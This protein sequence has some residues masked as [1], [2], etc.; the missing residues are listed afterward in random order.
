MV[1]LASQP[2]VSVFNADLVAGI[3]QEI[4]DNRRAALCPCH[5]T[6][7]QLEFLNIAEG[8]GMLDGHTGVIRDWRRRILNEVVDGYWV[9][10]IKHTQECPSLMLG[11]SGTGHQLL[12]VAHSKSVPSILTLDEVRSAK[13]NLRSPANRL[14]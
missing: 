8:R 7:G 10:D 2:M 14:T 1:A 13:S 11:L 3:I 6:L 9:A 12:R 5:G 4:T